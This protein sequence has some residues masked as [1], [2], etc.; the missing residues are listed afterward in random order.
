MLL[1]SILFSLFLIVINQNK[2]ERASK[3]NELET[4]L[5]K[6]KIIKNQAALLQFLLTYYSEQSKYEAISNNNVS[7]FMIDKLLKGSQFIFIN[8]IRCLE[9]RII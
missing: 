2:I 6:I 8:F 4:K 3:F 5:S 1:L 7:I 9:M